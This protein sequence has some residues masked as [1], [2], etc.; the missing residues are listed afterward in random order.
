MPSHADRQ[1]S[2]LAGPRSEYLVNIVLRSGDLDRH[3]L[4][5][6]APAARLGSAIDLLQARSRRLAAQLEHAPDALVEV[7]EVPE[8]RLDHGEQPL[9][10]LLL[11]ALRLG[12]VGGSGARLN[13]PRV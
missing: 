11:E 12:R 9:S 6:D 10:I 8:A 13:T 7:G 2:R 5:L 4:K 3:I 1:A